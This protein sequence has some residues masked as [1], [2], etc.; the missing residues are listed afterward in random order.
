MF[1][2][3]FLNFEISESLQILVRVI[4][5]LGGAIVGWFAA[6]PL[7]RIAYRV[8]FK[9]PTPMTVLLA[10]KGV[11]AA[12]L[13]LVLYSIVGIGLGGGLGFGPGQGG[14]PGKGPGQ[15][16]DK[17]PLADG[18]TKS[19]GKTDSPT[20]VVKKS[21][22]I[23]PVEIEIIRR[24]DDDG[25]GR[26]F[27]VKGTKPAL[28]AAELEDYLKKNH[29]RI[30]VTPVLTRDSI[31]VGQINNPLSQLLTLTKKYDVKTFQTRGP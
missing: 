16:G 15:G 14:V 21:M 29:A 27:L 20:K 7:T 8:S 13:A 23:E 25:S 3:S 12:L 6:D 22:T 11:S 19:D 26:Y 10:S 9:G 4:A 28:T 1:A 24:D 5:A 17:T 31:G 2:Q 30:E 18:K